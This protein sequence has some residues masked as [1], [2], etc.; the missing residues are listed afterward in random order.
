MD[1]STS[2]T[3]QGD[4]IDAERLYEKIICVAVDNNHNIMSRKLMNRDGCW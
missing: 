3:L 1:L 4:Q 2:H